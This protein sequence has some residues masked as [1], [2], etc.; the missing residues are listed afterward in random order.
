[1]AARRRQPQP[2]YAY[3]ARHTRT[4]RVNMQYPRCLGLQVNDHLALRT[5]LVG[6]SLTL[7]DLVV[8]GVV[9]PAVVGVDRARIAWLRF[10]SVFV[11]WRTQVLVCLERIGVAL[12]MH[13]L[14]M[15]GHAHAHVR[16]RVPTQVAFPE[17]QTLHFCNLL[18]W[19]DFIQHLAGPA[20]AVLPKQLALVKPK[21]QPP[22]P[23]PKV[24]GQAR[25][26]WDG[27]LWTCR[28]VNLPA[29]SYPR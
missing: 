12:R 15:H 24:G 26:A 25:V 27:A 9:Q 21:F 8:F 16:T 19:Y 29:Y 20:A 7:A 10:A 17:A 22:P 23:A 5:F 11:K 28:R 13:R 18:R 6:S 1:M 4:Q 3:A 2:R 14:C